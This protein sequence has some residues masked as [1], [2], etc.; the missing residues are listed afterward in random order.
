MH[1]RTGQPV[2]E[3]TQSYWQPSP[4][5]IIAPPDKGEYPYDGIEEKEIIISFPPTFMIFMM[6]VLIKFP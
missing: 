5:T 3:Y 4:K 1:K 2:C 6:M